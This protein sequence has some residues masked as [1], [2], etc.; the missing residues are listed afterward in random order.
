[1]KPVNASSNHKTTG[2]PMGRRRGAWSVWPKLLAGSGYPYTN[3]RVRVMRS[4]LFAHSEIMRLVRLTLPEIALQLQQSEYQT[5]IN[6]LARTQ[7]GANLIEYALNRN[8]ENT[9]RRILGFSI[10]VANDQIRLYLQRYDVYNIKTFLAGKAA[11]KK[12]EAI[13]SELVCA[14]ALSRSFFERAVGRANDFEGAIVELGGTEYQPIALEFQSDLAKLQ[15]ELDKHYYR[16]VVDLAEPDLLGFIRDEIKAKNTLNWMRAQKN[17]LTLDVL[18]DESEREFRLPHAGESVENRVF[19]KKFLL[20]RG[21]DMAREF[22]RNI[23]PVLGYLIAKENEVAN[24]RIIARGKKAGLDEK[25]IE[26]Q[27]V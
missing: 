10:R 4:K 15:D 6:A 13:L 5:E 7:E 11:R 9:F 23:R 20:K 17:N 26:N 1:M 27:I 25:T 18:P 2:T 19:L 12:N 8:L 22:K 14:G 21:G 3:T 16:K 24:I